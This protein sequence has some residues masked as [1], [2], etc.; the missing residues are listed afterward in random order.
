MIASEAAGRP[1]PLP[2][3]SAVISFTPA[4]RP[5]TRP[6]NACAASSQRSADVML[7]PFASTTAFWRGTFCGTST[8]IKTSPPVTVSGREESARISKSW[9]FFASVGAATTSANATITVASD[10]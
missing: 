1:L 6:V 8:S 3:A 10:A 4:R 9:A 5:L 7:V 2:F